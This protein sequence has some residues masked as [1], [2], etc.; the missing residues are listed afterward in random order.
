MGGFHI[1][2]LI[3]GNT[4]IITLIVSNTVIMTMSMSMMMTMTMSTMNNDGKQKELHTNAASV[5]FSLIEG[6]LA[7]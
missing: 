7:T 4:I 6:K 3:K 1:F 5:S 2:S